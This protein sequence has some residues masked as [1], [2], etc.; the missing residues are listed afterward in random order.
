MY[1]HERVSMCGFPDHS[2][3]SLELLHSICIS[4]HNVLSHSSLHCS[5]PSSLFFLFRSL[6]DWGKQ[7]DN[8]I[9]RFNE[10]LNRLYFCVKE[11]WLGVCLGLIDKHFNGFFPRFKMFVPSSSF[12]SSLFSFLFSLS[13]PLFYLIFLFF[14]FL[15]LRVKRSEMDLFGIMI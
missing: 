13:F 9:Y 10:P 4:I 8:T 3:P 1:F 12:F 5:L 7:N 11:R 15:F 14:F 6:R 2:A